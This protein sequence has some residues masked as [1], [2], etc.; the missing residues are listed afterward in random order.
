MHASIFWIYQIYPTKV[1]AFN[2]FVLFI[3]PKSQQASAFITVR[4]GKIFKN[5]DVRTV[6]SEVNAELELY[7]KML[8][9]LNFV[10]KF[11]VVKTHL[12]WKFHWAL[13][14]GTVN[15]SEVVNQSTGLVEA[16]SSD[17]QLL[18]ESKAVLLKL[19]AF[20]IMQN[21]TLD[22]NILLLAERGSKCFWVIKGK[23]INVNISPSF[24]QN[25]VNFDQPE[26]NCPTHNTFRHRHVG[27]N[28]HL[29]VYVFVEHQ[30]LKT[31]L[32]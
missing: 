27:F 17:K 26:K 32:Y 10:I 12:W 13:F 15:F 30:F 14:N 25:T 21:G 23:F 1:S 3:C 28:D 6:L 4:G 11:L 18:R 20:S 5:K 7:N 24:A 8:F 19:K 2:N 29:S 31:A 9:Q 16:I 22:G